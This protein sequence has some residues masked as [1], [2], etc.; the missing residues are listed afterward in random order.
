M[1]TATSQHLVSRFRVGGCYSSPIRKRYAIVL[2]VGRSAFGFEVIRFCFL[3]EHGT[4]G[5]A[6]LT[7]D[8]FVARYFIAESD[9]P[10]AKLTAY[11]A[12]N[13]RKPADAA[14]S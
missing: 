1:T 4:L 8:E 3:N 5:V 11:A 7:P 12:T 14:I 10:P 2:D 6:T 13:P 9:T